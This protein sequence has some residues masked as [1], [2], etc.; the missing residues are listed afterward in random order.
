MSTRM[1]VLKLSATLAAAIASGCSLPAMDNLPK[2]AA[3]PQQVEI[4]VKVDD[5]KITV[6]DAKIE[7][8]NTAAVIPGSADRCACGCAKQGCACSD[9]KA[10]AAPRAS[11]QGSKPQVIK[12]EPKLAWQ[13]RDGICGWWPVEEPVDDSRSKPVAS[14]LQPI[15]VYV[16]N[17]PASRAMRAIINETNGLR[18]SV[19]GT[20]PPIDGFYWWPTAVKRDGE[21]W[22][23]GR[24]GWRAGSAAEFERWRGR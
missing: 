12:K 17:D 7:L 13:C 1:L 14:S 22:T 23:P 11:S 21:T 19:S 18:Y 9:S 3:T 24:A 15:T 20:P 2:Q 16:S 4:R 6:N 10:S 8:R 5:G